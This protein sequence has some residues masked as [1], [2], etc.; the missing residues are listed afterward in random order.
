MFEI[1]DNQAQI[2]DLTSHLLI[3]ATELVK[4]GYSPQFAEKAVICAVCDHHEFSM[5]ESSDSQW[6]IEDVHDFAEKNIKDDYRGLI[7][8]DFLYQML[9]PQVP[10]PQKL[11]DRGTHTRLPSEL[12]WLMI[13]LMGSDPHKNL[14]SPYLHS[15]QLALA[16]TVLSRKVV[17]TVPEGVQIAN[18]LSKGIKNL[19]VSSQ[20][21][22][23]SEAT[24]ASREQCERLCGWLPL[25]KHSFRLAFHIAG[26]AYTQSITEMDDLYEMAVAQ[27]MRSVILVSQ[28]LLTST[29]AAE[30][31]L[32]SA[33]LKAGI[34][35]AVIE[36]PERI[37]PG[38]RWKNALLVLDSTYT[39]KEKEKVSLLD[40]SS[41]FHSINTHGSR[42]PTLDRWDLI[43]QVLQLG[44]HEQLVQV[45][46]DD[47]DLDFSPKR[48]PD[49]KPVSS[50]LKTSNYLLL[51][52][53]AEIRSCQSLGQEIVDVSEAAIK[54]DPNLF[55]E[56]SLRDINEN[57]ILN[58][59]QKV[60][61][62]N[63]LTTPKRRRAILKPGDILLSIKGVIGQ[64][65]LVTDVGGEKWVPNQSF[66]LIRAKEGYSPIIL[67]YQLLSDEIQELLQSKATG[68]SICQ[69][70]VQ[71]VKNLPLPVLSEDGQKRILEEYKEIRQVD[72]GI[73][74]LRKLRRQR[75]QGIN[76]LLK[77]KRIKKGSGE[78]SKKHAWKSPNDD[79]VWF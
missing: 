77:R 21:E 61:R 67:F 31:K 37:V 3:K 51:D 13:S 5:L 2:R 58:R 14:Y 38:L 35:E 24:V 41:G 73:L 63:K 52:E 78:S 25:Q 56:A 48:R 10:L 62:T 8:S 27:P 40:A 26:E 6:V 74:Q 43:L 64:V 69:V 76:E 46:A 30:S 29:G 34:L 1:Q 70:K 59:P 50:A 45:Q 60:V 23:T 57:S 7:L 75:L 18:V 71:D 44:D 39:R 16:C 19:K 66:Q 42:L 20:H 79:F 33:I 11:L 55:L 9:V 28:G 12:V 65:G 47:L 32:K 17:C 22:S 15:I 68:S 4:N 54:K 36:L 49:Y 53:V 72:A